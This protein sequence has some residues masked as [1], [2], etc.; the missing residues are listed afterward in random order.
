[1]NISQVAAF[2]VVVFS[3]CVSSCTR[4]L[5]YRADI[6]RQDEISARPSPGRAPNSPP[7]EIDMPQAD[8]P[9]SLK[10]VDRFTKEIAPLR[11]DHN[12]DEIENRARSYAE[13]KERFIGGGWKLFSLYGL[14]SA[15]DGVESEDN[16]TAHIRAIE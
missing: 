7:I 2:F 15:P 12:F 10:E 9:G 6:S 1:M 13:T 4:F 11:R 5:P 14:A 3:F 8:I 16:Y